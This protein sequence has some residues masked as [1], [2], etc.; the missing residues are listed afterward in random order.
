MQGLSFYI[1]RFPQVDRK[2]YISYNERMG[3]IGTLE[4]RPS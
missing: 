3:S 2:I 4:R 1:F